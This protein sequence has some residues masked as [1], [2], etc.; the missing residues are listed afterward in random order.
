[1]QWE[2]A[3]PIT[4]KWSPHYMVTG[5]ISSSIGI[6]YWKSRFPPTYVPRCPLTSCQ[7]IRTHMGTRGLFHKIGFLKKPHWGL[8]KNLNSVENPILW[9]SIKFHSWGFSKDLN[10]ELR[11]FKRP[12]LRVR[13]SKGFFKRPASGQVFSKNLIEV[14]SWIRHEEMRVFKKPHCSFSENLFYG[15]ALRGRQQTPPRAERETDGVQLG[16]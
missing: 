16:D 14:F 3:F 8:L 2:R 1:M 9:N 11:F 6:K 4:P 5:I 10:S 12:Q 7:V 13:W 15:T